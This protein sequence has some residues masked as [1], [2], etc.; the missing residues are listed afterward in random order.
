MIGTNM[1]QRRT[2]WLGLSSTLVA[3]I[4]VPASFGIGCDGGVDSYCAARCDCQ[5]CSQRETE[6]CLDDVEDSE[7]LAEFDGCDSKFSDYISCYTSE[8]ECQSGAWVAS[9]CSSK[10]SVLRECSSRA[11]VFVKTA[12]EE[13]KDKRA[14]C[15]LSGGGTNPCESVDECVAFCALGASCDE[16]A[17][18]TENSTYV[19][20]VIGCTT[21]GS[22]TSSGGGP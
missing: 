20:C 16:L 22:S 2:R 9:T 13:E 11:A 4:V 17:N 3:S 14:S 19:N 15:G 21:S 10:G 6:D 5:G 8:G 1:K 12:C 18:P 7:R